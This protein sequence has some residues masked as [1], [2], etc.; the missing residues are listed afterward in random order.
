MARGGA[1][2]PGVLGRRLA[3]AADRWVPDPFVIALLLTGMTLLAGLLSGTGPGT[4]CLAFGRGMMEPGLLAFGFQ[5]ALV[6]ATGHAIAEASGMRAW[7][8]GL[9]ERPAT[10]SQAAALVAACAMLL[11]LLNWGLGLIG[12]A[13]LAR[14]V[15][16]VFAQRGRPLCYPLVAAAGY[17][18][19]LVWHGG[20][21]GS[22]PLKVAEGGF[23]G[24]SLA[25]HQT[26]LSPLNLV[27]TPLVVLVVCG[28]YALL[29][30]AAPDEP[31]PAPDTPSARPR[32]DTRSRPAGRLEHSLLVLLLLALPI[33][34]ALGLRAAGEGVEA[35]DLGFVILLFW[36]VGLLAHRSPR[37]Y[38]HA[39][40]GGARQCG[41][42]LLQFPIYFGIL[43]VAREAGLVTALA[44]SFADL[45]TAL[46]GLIPVSVTAPAGTL[47]SSAVVN[48]LVPSGGGQ[49]ALQA[50]VVAETTRLL[51][52]S[53]GSMVLAFAYGDQL[54]NML[55][56]FWALPL[57]SITGLEARQILGYTL[58]VM[59]V[60]GPLFLAGVMLGAA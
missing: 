20:L 16:R 18:A 50:P 29:G 31:A 15:G 59:M 53:P 3:G 42:I 48:L 17:S 10:T 52:L 12:G 56:P 1:G 13:F 38:A 9:A 4:L 5:M 21:S 11:G 45:A 46:E 51:D 44:R 32:Q 6:L 33:L 30:N 43:G 27:V 23:F 14:E 34:A 37:A 41:G 55:Q 47:A 24:R 19:L 58:L 22:A 26:I 8:R 7:L 57:L 25:I 28:L 35:V 40:A 39:F 2:I 60:A 49:W 54:T 36:V